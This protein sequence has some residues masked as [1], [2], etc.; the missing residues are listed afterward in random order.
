M[1]WAFGTL[2]IYYYCFKI[3]SSYS[4]GRPVFKFRTS[5]PRQTDVLTYT[6]N[7][8]KSSTIYKVAP[9]TD[10]QAS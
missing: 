4:S 10:S 6:N 8:M 1:V 7:L 3:G 2:V 9:Y 5:K